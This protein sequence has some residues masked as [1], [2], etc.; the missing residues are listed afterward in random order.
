MAKNLSKLLK[1]AMVPVVAGSIF[2]NTYLM[3]PVYAA[4]KKKQSPTNLTA[5]KTIYAPV[6]TPETNDS[7]SSMSRE[8]YKLQEAKKEKDKKEFVAGLRAKEKEANKEKKASKEASDSQA[9]KD[10][11]AKTLQ[12]KIVSLGIKQ[13]DTIYDGSL[14][15]CLTDKERVIGQIYNNVKKNLDSNTKVAGPFSSGE[16]W[17]GEG[18][19]GEIYVLEIPGDTFIE[20]I[21]KDGK[22]KDIANWPKTVLDNYIFY[23]AT[24][25]K[26]KSAS[27]LKNLEEL[28]NFEIL[29]SKKE[30]N[31]EYRYY[32]VPDRIPQGKKEFIDT[33]G[34]KIEN[35]I[36]TEV[37]FN[38]SFKKANEKTVEVKYGKIYDNNK[39]ANSDN[40]GAIDNEDGD[41]FNLEITK[42]GDKDKRDVGFKIKRTALN[43][44][45]SDP[46]QTQTVAFL[47]VRNLGNF[48]VGY[49]GFNV[50]L[51]K[52]TQHRYNATDIFAQFTPEKEKGII[53]DISFLTN[54]GTD[55][56]TQKASGSYWNFV[57]QMTGTAHPQINLSGIAEAL[58]QMNNNLGFLLGNV[59]IEASAR[60]QEG[61]DNI[62]DTYRNKDNSVILLQ[63]TTTIPSNYNIIAIGAN[64]KR[65][66]PLKNGDFKL[67]EMLELERNMFNKN[68]QGTPYSK[69]HKQVRA[70]VSAILDLGWLKGSVMG[71]GQYNDNKAGTNDENSS[72]R[73]YQIALVPSENLGA[74]INHFSDSLKNTNETKVSL[75]LGSPYANEHINKEM[76]LSRDLARYNRQ[77]NTAI[78][79]GIN[80]SLSQLQWFIPEGIVLNLSEGTD[81][82]KQKIGKAEVDIYSK[83]KIAGVNNIFGV[84][85]RIEAM[86]DTNDK[87]KAK[88]AEVGVKIIY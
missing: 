7:S 47:P 44:G 38:P 37:L 20:Y 72:I 56:Q 43:P 5:P 48:L 81:E 79:A 52:D 67:E 46:K 25:L 54:F 28:T 78:K 69:E 24:N 53:K 76:K 13:N 39:G 18:K 11:G 84:Y 57:R 60:Y 51:D 17:N 71:I 41:A 77:N 65:I 80:P 29:G 31:T 15:D 21:V 8:E 36:I 70:G 4:Q 82:F 45:L 55:T 22:I 66:I 35:G 19:D 1:Y 58:P 88:K 6:E 83:N 75:I 34:Y 49:N 23:T 42:V 87:Y 10:K 74:Y 32:N 2:L 14:F 85:G 3:N 16:V 62:I 50:L 9:N 64:N 63:S 40:I 68:N 33:V 61:K 59:E 30:G 12:G 26:D 86:K 73:N 27:I